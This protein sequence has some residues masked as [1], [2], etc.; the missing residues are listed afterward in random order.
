MYKRH[1]WTV[2][3][4]FI[5]FFCCFG[6]FTSTGPATVARYA[7]GGANETGT[8][9]ESLRLMSLNINH[10]FPNFQSL[11][12][13]LRFVIAEIIKQDVD[14]AF[15]QEVPWTRK[16]GSGADFFAMG[17]GLNTLYAR[18]NG[19]YR[20]IGFEEGSV[21]LSRY[22]LRRAGHAELQPGAWMFDNRIVLH[23]EAITPCGAISLFNTH[24][25]NDNVD[26]NSRQLDSLKAYVSAVK[27][28]AAIVAG[29]LNAADNSKRISLVTN[30]WIDA[31]HGVG[32]KKPVYTCCIDDFTSFNEQSLQER[33][34]YIFLVPGTDWQWSMAN[35][36]R[37]L[38]RPFKLSDGWSWVSD[39]VG[40]L[41]DLRRDHHS[42][43]QST[44]AR[45][46]APQLADRRSGTPQYPTTVDE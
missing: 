7:D 1:L 15:L 45:V 6:Y 41:V 33:I 44:V 37:I 5:L 16:L 19:S 40:L 24:L 12:E 20:F 30:E 43:A 2:I 38:D 14:L 23:A 10:D 11:E 22:P 17:T 35:A 4:V 31:F 29:D 36:R 9:K 27:G 34:D 3:I 42:T 26:V 8:C 18:A 32:A 46:N 28:G 39:H 25:V 13:R 21:I